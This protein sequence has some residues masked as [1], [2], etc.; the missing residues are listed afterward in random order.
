MNGAPALKRLIGAYI[1]ED[2]AEFYPD[3]WSAVDDFIVGAP[4]LARDLPSEIESV[5]RSH[6]T[7][8]DLEAFLDALG[9]GYQPTEEEGGYQGWLDQV[10]LRAAAAA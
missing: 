5:L 9:V 10:R 6:S 3:V 1:N 2:W 8:D 7:E 4:L